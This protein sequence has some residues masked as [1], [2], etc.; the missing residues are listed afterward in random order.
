VASKNLAGDI[1]MTQ[2]DDWTDKHITFDG[3]MYIAWNESGGD[4]IGF[5]L[6]IEQARKALK[7]YAA[8][9]DRTS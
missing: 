1:F 8:D 6:T 7:E 5:F 4:S 2:Q 3:S 9:L